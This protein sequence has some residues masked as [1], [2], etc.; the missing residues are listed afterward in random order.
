MRRGPYGKPKIGSN[1]P[2]FRRAWRLIQARKTHAG[3][4]EMPLFEAPENLNEI[5][6]FDLGYPYA[7]R[8][9]GA[10]IE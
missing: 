4:P 9:K 5:K 2:A 10:P 3:P 1:S 6:G 7:E 8:I